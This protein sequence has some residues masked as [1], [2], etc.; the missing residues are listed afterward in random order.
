MTYKLLSVGPIP[1]LL[2]LRNAV[3][4]QAGFLVET[5]SDLN[6]AVRLFLDEDFD[7]AILCHSIPERDKARLIRLLKENKPLTPVAALSDGSEASDGVA[8][9]NLDLV[10]NNLDGPETLLKQVCSMIEKASP[11]HPRGT[12]MAQRRTN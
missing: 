8:S 10:I 2:T 12:R 11:T 9:Q 3:L 6:E 4:R 7:A 5:S 1:E